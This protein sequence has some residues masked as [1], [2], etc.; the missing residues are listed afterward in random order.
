MFRSLTFRPPSP[1]SP[2]A[3]TLPSPGNTTFSERLDF[4]SSDIVAPWVREVKIIWER[5]EHSNTVDNQQA[6]KVLSAKLSRFERLS[7]I[8]AEWFTF[9]STHLQALSMCPYL[10][11]VNLVNCP[12]EPTYHLPTAQCGVVELAFRDGASVNGS[13]WSPFISPVTTR[14]IT[15]TTFQS[16]MQLMDILASKPVMTQLKHLTLCSASPSSPRFLEALSRC[17]ALET[18]RFVGED[19]YIPIISALDKLPSSI[20]PHLTT[21]RA[22]VEFFPSYIAGRPLKEIEVTGDFDGDQSASRFIS[23]LHD[24]Y[25]ELTSLRLNTTG[26]C[27]RV[28]VPLL[29]KF[30]CLEECYLEHRRMTNERVLEVIIF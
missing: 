9:N 27:D 13:W 26:V 10:K 29:T 15:A 17:P 6:Y 8:H 24:Y 19:L 28:L 7:K 23:D 5:S 14:T 4:L 20:I 12:I 30:R 1:S 3:S 22:S 11:R 25:P 16:S 2:G 18:L 21:I